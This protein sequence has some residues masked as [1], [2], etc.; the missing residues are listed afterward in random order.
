MSHKQSVRGFPGVPRSLL[1][2]GPGR[3]PF[4]RFTWTLSEETRVHGPRPSTASSHATH[5]RGLCQGP[6]PPPATCGPLLSTMRWPPAG[7]VLPGSLGGLSM[8]PPPGHVG[9]ASPGT[10]VVHAWALAGKALVPTPL[11]GPQVWARP[12]AAGVAGIARRPLCSV[13]SRAPFV[14]LCLVFQPTLTPAP[15]PEES[16]IHPDRWVL[17]VPFLQRWVPSGDWRLG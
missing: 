8:M 3:G 5:G 10:S 4:A 6:A 17:G 15:T 2:D 14:L 12:E 16:G 13:G 9:R 11:V 7:V 1:T